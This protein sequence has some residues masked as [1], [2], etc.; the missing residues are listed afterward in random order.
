MGRLE[1]AIRLRGLLAGQPRFGSHR[2]HLS[3]GRF[4]ECSLWRF[5]GRGSEDQRRVAV[6]AGWKSA[7][8]QLDS[9]F[10]LLRAESRR[11][12]AVKCFGERLPCFQDRKSTRLNS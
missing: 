7:N 5:G 10:E 8:A 9:G 6:I 12:A 2:A 1:K 3:K 4:V 11:R